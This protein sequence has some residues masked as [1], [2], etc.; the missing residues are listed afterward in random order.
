MGYQPGIIR[1]AI[2]GMQ[3]P[4]CI[5]FWWIAPGFEILSK[6]RIWLRIGLHHASDFCNPIRICNPFLA[7][8]NINLYP[9]YFRER[10]RF[11]LMY[12]RLAAHNSYNGTYGY[13]LMHLCTYLHWQKYNRIP[14]F[15]IDT[16]S[17]PA[18][19]VIAKAEWAQLA[20]QQ[21][22]RLGEGERARPG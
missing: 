9:S 11:R 4:D 17:I 14:S 13:L 3:N 1:I 7:Q 5:P 16:E 6:K 12:N 8:I 10:N 20:W 2:A 21:R 15:S 18:S 22:S 19:S